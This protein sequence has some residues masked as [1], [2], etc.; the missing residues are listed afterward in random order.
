MYDYK[1]NVHSCVQVSYHSHANGDLFLTVRGLLHPVLFLTLMTNDGNVFA[2]LI[3]LIVQRMS[4]F[5]YSGSS[6]KIQ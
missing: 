5:R 6:H 4:T 1:L 3:R 2:V